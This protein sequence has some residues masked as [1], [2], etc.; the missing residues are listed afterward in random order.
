MSAFR[1]RGVKGD[2]AWGDKY[3]FR[4]YDI[5][6]RRFIYGVRGK[7]ISAN[8]AYI[9]RTQGSKFAVKTEYRH[10]KKGVLV[11]RTA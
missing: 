7:D 10:G 9:Q 8:L 3:G 6:E 11:T 1:P 4:R 2:G 5:G